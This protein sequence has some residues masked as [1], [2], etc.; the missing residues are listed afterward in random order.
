MTE[1]HL[2]CSPVCSG[3]CALPGQAGDAGHAMSNLR[4][5]AGGGLLEGLGAVGRPVIYVSHGVNVRVGELVSGLVEC[6]V[7]PE[8]GAAKPHLCIPHDH[9]AD[10]LL[11]PFL[12]LGHPYGS[13]T[14]FASCKR[15]C[16]RRASTGQLSRSAPT[17]AVI[18][19]ASTVVS[20]VSSSDSSRP[21][22]VPERAR[23]TVI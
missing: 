11:S 18:S 17:V 15:T 5:C 12:P 2:L 6:E 10:F 14:H 22:R 16:G 20:L 4:A 21:H 8:V 3:L 19:T 13:R 23:G 9:G 7:G 1:S